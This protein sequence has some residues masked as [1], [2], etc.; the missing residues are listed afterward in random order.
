MER[1]IWVSSV[2]RQGA[3]GNARSPLLRSTIA[4]WE[5]APPAAL[6]VRV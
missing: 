6:I 1:A 5:M 4:S 2:N 3:A